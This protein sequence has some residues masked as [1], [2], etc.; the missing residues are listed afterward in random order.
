MKRIYIIIS[1]LVSVHLYAFSQDSGEDMYKKLADELIKYTESIKKIAVIP[2]SYADDIKSVKDGYIISERLSIKLI[3]TGKFEVI[4]RSQLDKVLSELKLQNSGIIDSSSAKELGKVLGV[5]AIITGTLVLTADGRIEVNARVVRTDTAQAVGAA[6]VYVVKDWIGGD[7]IS[8]PAAP[9]ASQ[10]APTYQPQTQSKTYSNKTNSSFIDII[11]GYGTGKLDAT[12]DS[13]DYLPFPGL[14]G[15]WSEIN[16]IKVNGIG[17]VGV[18]IGGFGKSIIGGDFEFSFSK[19]KTSKQNISWTNGQVL[20]MPEG[21]FD[22]SSFD[23]IGDILI[24]TMTEVQ[25][26][27]GF[28]LG[29]G[30]SVIKSSY[31]TDYRGDKL[32]DASL[33]VLYRI[34]FGLRFNVDNNTTL[35][36]E[37]RYQGYVTNFSRDYNSNYSHNLSFSG[38]R[39][40]VGI[41]GKF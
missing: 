17:P 41:G 10:N 6:Q 25:F 31:I 23:F 1:L 14:S 13:G 36:T 12:A 9:S 11:M 39:F 29:F 22:V 18:R 33:G 30:L 4:E 32:N 5:D 15:T 8:K 27:F 40:V 7:N 38:L 28:G 21:F 3:N 35:F 16:D 26:Y 37:F 24:R 20:P 34:P 2:F 19:Y